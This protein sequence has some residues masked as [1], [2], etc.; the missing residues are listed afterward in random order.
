[1]GPAPPLL[2]GRKGPGKFPDGDEGVEGPGM[3]S[4]LGSGPP[5]CSARFADTDRPAWA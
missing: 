5:G 2:C 4:N 1:M 3:P